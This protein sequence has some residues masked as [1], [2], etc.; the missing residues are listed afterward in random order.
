MNRTDELSG[1]IPHPL[2]AKV[3]TNFT[4]RRLSLKF[5]PTFADRGCQLRSDLKEKV[6]A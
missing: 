3:G 5:V 6:A 1:L 4:D 2:S